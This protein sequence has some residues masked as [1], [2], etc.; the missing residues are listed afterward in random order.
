MAAPKEAALE[1]VLEFCTLRLCEHI[2]RG[3]SACSTLEKD[4]RALFSLLLNKFPVLC[5]SLL[6]HSRMDLRLP[7][8]LMYERTRMGACRSGHFNE[9]ICHSLNLFTGPTNY[10]IP[11]ADARKL[12]V[13]DVLNDRLHSINKLEAMASSDAL[14][15]NLVANHQ[16]P[17][18]P[19][20]L[21]ERIVVY[22]SRV[23][24]VAASLQRVKPPDNIAHCSNNACRRMFYIGRA[25]ETIAPDEDVA[26]LDLYTDVVSGKSAH[27]RVQRCFCTFACYEEHRFHIS[28]EIP[29]IDFSEQ[30]RQE[31]RARVGA[32]LRIALRRNEQAS[33]ILRARDKM[34]RP[35]VVSRND[36][37][38]ERTRLIT[39]LNVDVGLLFAASL[40]ADARTL[41]FGR[42]LPGTAEGWRA[43]P[44]FFQRAS[45]TILTL[46]RRSQQRDIIRNLNVPCKF[47]TL[48]KSKATDIF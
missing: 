17:N 39:A 48:L 24:G 4:Q 45:K 43:R 23:N 3:L 46:Y 44:M 31:G 12:T 11:D 41:S 10:I 8:L 26:V 40:L 35:K 28:T 18:L 27:R 42:I 33:R 16:L 2:Q 29:T 14:F 37:E 19:P 25:T 20:G 7:Y 30:C 34:P 32:A 47:T 6:A 21:P 38:N 5:K 15:R 22:V 13:R 1:L 36:I 9:G